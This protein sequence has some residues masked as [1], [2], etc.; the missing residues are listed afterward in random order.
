MTESSLPLTIIIISVVTLVNVGLITW[1]ISNR[2]P[3][4]KKNIQ[5]YHPP[6]TTDPK[7]Q[8]STIEDQSHNVSPPSPI[9][10]MTFKDSWDIEQYDKI[11]RDSTLSYLNKQLNIFTDGVIVTIQ[12]LRISPSKTEMIVQ[13]S[14]N[15]KILLKEGIAEISKHNQSGHS[16]PILRNINSGKFIE[17]AKEVPYKAF[18]SRIGQ[19]STVVVGAAHIIAG[20]DIAKRLKDVE[21]KID[22]LIAMRRVDQLAKFERIFASA[23]ELARGK[24]GPIKRMEMWR[25]RGEL[26][27]L[28]ITWRREFEYQLQQIE[29]P[30]TNPW[31]QTMFTPHTLSLPNLLTYSPAL[32]GGK[33]IGK[34]FFERHQ[35]KKQTKKIAKITEGQAYLACIEYSLRLEHLL[36]VMSGTQDEFT[37]SLQDELFELDQVAKLLEGKSASVIQ[38]ENVQIMVTALKE[39]VLQYQNLI[40]APTQQDTQEINTFIQEESPK[41]LT[42]YTDQTDRDP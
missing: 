38:D 26:R 28:R 34:R 29:D 30:K 8:V 20:A 11:C 5:E 32:E 23:K 24:M 3:R 7:P 33:L 1:L 4:R 42:P 18:L 39:I 31:L 15:G 41:L 12:G 13:F 25:L 21:Q 36:S 16:L 17:Q 10:E 2:I 37:G 19:I 6:A 22:I 14:Q 9:L 40:P 27:E 35:Q